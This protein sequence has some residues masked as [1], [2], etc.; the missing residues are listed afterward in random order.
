VKRNDLQV[1]QPVELLLWE[2]IQIFGLLKKCLRR[3][4]NLG[5]LLKKE[6]GWDAVSSLKELRTSHA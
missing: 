5:V 4:T 6:V 1:A 3:T 2:W